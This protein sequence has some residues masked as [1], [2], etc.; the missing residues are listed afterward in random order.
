M[1]TYVTSEV[2]KAQD[3]LDI[4]NVEEASKTFLAIAHLKP[5]DRH[6]LLRLSL[7][8]FASLVV[9]MAMD[10]AV[11]ALVRFGPAASRAEIFKRMD[12]LED[13][14]Y[15]YE[16]DPLK[17][18]SGSAKLAMEFLKAKEQAVDFG[19]SSPLFPSNL[20]MRTSSPS[21]PK[22]EP[23]ALKETETL[24]ENLKSLLKPQK[25]SSVTLCDCATCA[26]ILGSTFSSK[27]CLKPPSLASGSGG[28][29]GGGGVGGDGKKRKSKK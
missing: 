3:L 10:S 24:T 13:M 27:E 1:D 20:E 15:T 25:L 21:Q 23:K 14:I 17:T 2:K 8:L 18:D 5:H 28:G 11:D 19:W 26:P 22:T 6:P 7:R 4:G 9:P 12:E 29:G 16:N